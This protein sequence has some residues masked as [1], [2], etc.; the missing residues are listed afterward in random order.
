MKNRKQVEAVNN[1]R[2][3]D[4]TLKILYNSNLP[5]KDEQIAFYERKKVKQEQILHNLRRYK[6]LGH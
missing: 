1:L 2:K 4:R 6:K 3:C 5:N